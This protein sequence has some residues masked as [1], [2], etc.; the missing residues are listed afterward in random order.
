M[1]RYCYFVAWIVAQHVHR[2]DEYIAAHIL[3]H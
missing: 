1:I 3:E 2:L